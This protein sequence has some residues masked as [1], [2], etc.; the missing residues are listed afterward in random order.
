MQV[1]LWFTG[2]GL[3]PLL[4]ANVQYM[5][6]S[7]KLKFAHTIITICVTMGILITGVV[8]YEYHR[9]DTPIPSSVLSVFFT[10]FGSELGL[11]CIRQIL[12]QDAISQIKKPKEPEGDVTS[13]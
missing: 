11:I 13:I 9:L 3:N 6:K 12:G 2:L 5:T 1:D 10:F 8:L 7:K 4:C